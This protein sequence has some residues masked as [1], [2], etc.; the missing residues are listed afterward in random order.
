MVEVSGAL[1]DFAVI[2]ENFTLL[3][4]RN[5]FI[6]KHGSFLSPPLEWNNVSPHVSG[7]PNACANSTSD[8]C[9]ALL[10]AIVTP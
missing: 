10:R 8:G 7:I 1:T 4:L 3:T 5:A 9:E 2:A 6:V